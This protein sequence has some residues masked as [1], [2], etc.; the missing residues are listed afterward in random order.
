MTLEWKL[1]KLHLSHTGSRKKVKSEVEYIFWS[2][3]FIDIVD[4]KKKTLNI[5]KQKIKYYITL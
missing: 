2:K 1:N 4:I 3:P 5:F